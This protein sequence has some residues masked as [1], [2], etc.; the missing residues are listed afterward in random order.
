MDII[1]SRRRSVADG[2][3]L[4]PDL[5]S[6]FLDHAKKIGQPLR[7]DE[8]QSVVMNVMIA[9]RDTT[10]CALSWGFYELTKRPEVIQNI[11]KEVVDI[12][13]K[14]DPDYSYDKIS[15]LRYTHAVVM[16]I[17]RLHRNESWTDDLCF[18]GAATLSTR[19]S[20]PVAGSRFVLGDVGHWKAE[21]DAAP[22]TRRKA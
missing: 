9:G 13:G 4:G 10:A 21:V 22:A 8:L 6:R 14:D 2:D 20:H 15:E 5:L 1:N 18:S 19:I 12:C 11:V 17:L 3:K 7:D 16:E